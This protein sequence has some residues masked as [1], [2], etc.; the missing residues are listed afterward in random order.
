VSAVACVWIDNLT[1]GTVERVEMLA[2]QGRCVCLGRALSLVRAVCRTA[3]GHASTPKQTMA[4]VERVE[5]LALQDRCVC[6]GRA[7]CHV[8]RG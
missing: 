7:L 4:I 2:L 1:V 3:V 5:T 6:L 8:S